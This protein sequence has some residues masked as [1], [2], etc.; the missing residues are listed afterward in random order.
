MTIK[1]LF[2]DEIRSHVLK[3]LSGECL[4]ERR[5]QTPQLYILSP[6]ISDVDI[7]FGD[8][9]IQK[10]KER[11]ENSFLFL[12]YNIKSIN[13]PYALLL[14]KLHSGAEVNIVTLPLEEMNVS[15]NYLPKVKTLFEFL[16]EIGCNV[17]VNS[18]LHSKL[19]LA[20]DLALLGSFNLTSSAL[21]NRE[22]IGISIN[23]LD[24][25]NLLE[26]YCYGVIYESQR[27]GYS[28][29]LNYGSPEDRKFESPSYVEGM[30]LKEYDALLKRWSGSEDAR[31]LSER[32]LSRR[33]RI[34][35]GY[36]LHEMIK[37]AYPALIGNEPYGEFFNVTGGYDKFIK[38]YASDLNLFYLMNL[39]RLISSVFAPAQATGKDWV[40]MFFGYEG[41]ESTDSIMEF[42]SS[43]FVRKTVPN[44]K[45]RVKSLSID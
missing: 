37:A 21:F 5:P 22:E 15:P 26:S 9:Y 29:L 11:A 24:N 12:D 8:L 20:N 23:D 17:F 6:W 18:K 13:L 30:T 32:Q 4:Y 28:S 43:K 35:R 14:L 31:I 25:L 10:E 19:L 33:N 44:V 27:Y 40:K 36:L 45:L 34:P 2:H 1:L 16:D 3:I 39:R 41:G 42:L 7:E 38:S